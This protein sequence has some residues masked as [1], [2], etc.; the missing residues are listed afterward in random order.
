MIRQTSLFGS[1]TAKTKVYKRK[2]KVATSVIAGECCVA[3]YMAQEE[4]CVCRCGGKYHG[5]GNPNWNRSQKRLELNRE[6]S[7]GAREA[8]E[9]QGY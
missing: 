5:V 4:V 8:A 9:L 1:T 2:T 6:V 3:C 7:A